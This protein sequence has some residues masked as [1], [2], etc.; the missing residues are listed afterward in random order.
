MALE[1]IDKF[2]QDFDTFFALV[3]HDLALSDLFCFV[4]CYHAELF[5]SRFRIFWSITMLLALDL[6]WIGLMLIG[7]LNFESSESSQKDTL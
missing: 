2:Y 3:F 4:S 7:W 6:H 1:K 5:Y